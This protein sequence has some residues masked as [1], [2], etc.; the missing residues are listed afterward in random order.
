[1][2]TS[3]KRKIEISYRKEKKNMAI[4][5]DIK[6]PTPN[7]KRKMLESLL[8]KIILMNKAKVID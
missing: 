6:K 4:K 2:N 3:T 7:I 8:K 5:S 1:M